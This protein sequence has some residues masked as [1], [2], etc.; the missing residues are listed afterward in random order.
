MSNVSIH[1]AGKTQTE[2]ASNQQGYARRGSH[3][4]ETLRKTASASP[5]TLFTQSL[6][7]AADRSVVGS[8][9][10]LQLKRTITAEQAKLYNTSLVHSAVDQAQA[11]EDETGAAILADMEKNN[12]D[13]RNRGT[14]IFGLMF[15]QHARTRDGDVE[16]TG[17]ADAAAEFLAELGRLEYFWAVEPA[18]DEITQVHIGREYKPKFPRDRL[19]GPVD[20]VPDNKK[21]F[22]FYSNYIETTEAGTKMVMNENFKNNDLAQEERSEANRNVVNN[23]DI[24][25]IVR[26]LAGGVG[27]E[28]DG[29]SNDPL[30]V[31]LVVRK[32]I[33]NVPTRDV[34]F[35]SDGAQDAD[36]DFHMGHDYDYRSLLG[37]PN[38]SGIGYAIAQ[39]ALGGSLEYLMNIKR[40]PTHDLEIRLERYKMPPRL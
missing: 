8:A 29:G 12:A 36:S 9:N 19:I 35:L 18:S 20:A 11:R 33:K 39:R 30:A 21:K 13:A 5:V 16:N 37:A 38:V 22:V 24:G 40:K 34:M 3:S 31:N 6:Q 2:H 4:L 26:V 15:N 27:V 25:W 7:S 28:D 32:N 23:S 14:R 10:P 1:T 17:G